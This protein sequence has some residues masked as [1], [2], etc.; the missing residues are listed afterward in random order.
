MRTICIV[1][2][3]SMTIFPSPTQL[4]FDSKFQSWRANQPQAIDDLVSSSKRFV[5]QA[6]GL[7]TGKSLCY[8]SYARVSRSRTMVLTS[9]KG[10][11]SQL[12]MD[13]KAN[14]LVDIRG[15]SNYKC[16]GLPGHTCEDGF[17]GKCMYAGE[18]CCTWGRARSLAM[19]ADLVTTNYSCWAATNRYGQGFGHFDLLILDE[20]HSAHDALCKALTITLTEH[21]MRHRLK[22]GW[23]DRGSDMETWKEWSLS[24]LKRAEFAVQGLKERIAKATHPSDSQIQDYRAMS[25]LKRKL[26]DIARC[27]AEDWCVE[28]SGSDFKFD[29]IHAENYAEDVLFRKTPRV[30]LVSGTIQPHTLSGLGIDLDDF[31]FYEYPRDINPSRTPLIFIPTAFID[32]NSS[33][34]SLGQLVERIDEIIESRADRRGIIHTGNFAL[35]DYITQNSKYSDLMISNYTSDGDVTSEVIK[36]FKAMRPPVILVTPSVT[37]GYDF[38]HCVDADTRILTDDLRWVRA[39]DLDIGDGL[40]GFEE[41]LPEADRLKGGR[42]RRWKRS[43]V[44]SNSVIVKPRY[45]LTFDD[46]TSVICSSDHIWLAVNSR[47]S[48][49]WMKTSFLRN[50]PKQFCHLLKLTDVWGEIPDY[51]RGY[52][53]ALFDGEGSFC[54]YQNQCPKRGR[55]V[56]NWASSLS[57]TQVY[58]DVLLAGWNLLNKHGYNPKTYA[59]GNRTDIN[60]NWQDTATVNVM[61]NSNKLRFLG[62]VRPIRLLPK[63]DWGHYGTLKGK[64]VKLVEKEFLGDGPVIALGTT[65]RTFVAEGIA[66]HN[67]DCRY[68]IIAKLPFPD[69]FSSKV[70]QERSK[71]NPARGIEIMWQHLAQAF[72]RADRSPE[73]WAECFILDNN[74]EQMMWRHSKLAPPWLLPFYRKSLEVP[75]PTRFD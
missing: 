60:P 35:R 62:Q 34:W 50:G 52:L 3:I 5:G 41:H 73:D 42:S 66:S 10:L 51:D 75:I 7:G 26:A 40:A 17:I 8:M 2:L 68:Q 48:H 61:G 13:F 53:A 37:T 9:T 39:G 56:G 44:I 64:S 47:A 58:N 46:G 23:P 67:S 43:E 11:Q 19:E 20:A 54:F 28:R 55:A 45:R 70:E 27:R 15:K 72:G 21:D 49:H 63:M 36:K 6:M 25:N 33:D 38:P 16:V 14:G 1:I 71:A 24:A 29:P 74:V 22:Y 4:G 59:K 65:T 57:F 30:V 31:D 69:T 32:R 18:S 12:M